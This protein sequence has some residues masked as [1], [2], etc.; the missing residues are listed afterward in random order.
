MRANDE[1]LDVALGTMADGDNVT[2][3]LLSSSALGTANVVDNT[4]S[5]VLVVGHYND[6]LR[7]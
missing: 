2:S 7:G 1:T 3:L 4:H 6:G 5:N